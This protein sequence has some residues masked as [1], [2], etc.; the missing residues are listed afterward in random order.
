M[1]QF[2][3]S[4]VLLIAVLFPVI[5]CAQG[6][7]LFR[8]GTIEQ[9]EDYYLADINLNVGKHHLIYRRQMSFSVDKG[10]IIPIWPDTKEK[11]DP[12]TGE[13]VE[14]YDE[15]SH[16]FKL[17]LYPETESQK[18]VSVV[19][20]YQGCSNQTCFFPAS[21]TFR[22][23]LKAGQEKQEQKIP[24]KADTQNKSADTTTRSITV[25][26]PSGLVD[27]ARTLH[28]KG[29]IWVL[30]LSF[31]GGL[32]VSLTPCVYPMI[33]ITLSIIGSRNENQSFYKGFGLSATYVAGLSL[34]YALLGLAA[35]TFGAS[36]RGILQGTLFQAA[37]SLVFFL[38]ALSMFDFFLLQAPGALRNRLS[39]IKKTGLFGIFIMG[40]VSGLMA[41]PCVA[42]PLAGILAFIAATGSQM[43]GFFMLL[44]FAWGMS[45][46]LLFIG[47]FSGAL[48]AMPKAGGWMN[49]VKEF[50]GFLLL[51]AALYFARPLVGE[52]WAEL[53][54][55]LVLAGFAAFLGL[56]S[57]LPDDSLLSHRVFKA[58]GV[59][60]IAV[61]CAFA[62]SA[63]SKWGFLILPQS[64]ANQTVAAKSEVFWHDNLTTALNEAQQR[65]VPVFVDFRADWCSICRELEEKVFPQPE[66]QMLLKKVVLV[67]IDATNPT[68][69][70]NQILQRFA[71]VGLPTLV[72][73]NKDGKEIEQLRMV[74]NITPDQLKYNLRQVINLKVD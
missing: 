42:A 1:R 29:M 36:I 71:V 67:K 10:R 59:V 16:L 44:M 72:L 60:T 33:P 9:V 41:S 48:N 64:I 18:E 13:N 27:F 26:T 14:V 74:G 6:D 54:I 39:S 3:L 24:A 37:I 17:K 35:A 65:K 45:V 12:F 5:L 34:T 11:K 2:N 56:F 50:Y 32:L 7:F 15:G 21:Q 25:Q 47:A 61:A 51:G 66:V 69:E 63:T 53:G 38:L 20:N 30:A 68:E 8:A 73:L 52:P 43:L 23:V 4:L 31:L 40:M 22:F 49:K 46:P 55:A 70:V 62:I 28:E 19:V 57:N 58:F